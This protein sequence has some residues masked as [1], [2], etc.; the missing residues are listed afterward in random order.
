[1]AFLW[2]ASAFLILSSEHILFAQKVLSGHIEFSKN[3][4]DF[5]LS[6]MESAS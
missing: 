2:A 3:A 1:M 5:L 6:D 4:N